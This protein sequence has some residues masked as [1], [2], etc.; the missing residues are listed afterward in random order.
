MTPTLVTS[1]AYGGTLPLAQEAG[2]NF[3]FAALREPWGGPAENF[4]FQGIRP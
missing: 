3:G 2:A 1:R 4:M